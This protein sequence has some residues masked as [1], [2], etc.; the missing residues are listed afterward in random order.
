MDFGSIIFVVS[1]REHV[2]FIFQRFELVILRSISEW[3]IHIESFFSSSCMLH[4]YLS[5]FYQK[6]DCL[7][8]KES[9]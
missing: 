7:Q 8:R 6:F 4:N 3:K 9:T 1:G 5:Y 2:N